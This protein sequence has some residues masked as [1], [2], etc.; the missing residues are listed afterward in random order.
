MRLRKRLSMAF[1]A[2]G[3]AIPTSLSAAIPPHCSDAPLTPLQLTN[4]MI[5]IDR[6]GRL[7]D[8]ASKQ[9]VIDENTYVDKLL[10]NIE[11]AKK[12]GEITGITLYIHGGLNRWRDAM[13]RASTRSGCMLADQKYPVFIGWD[14]RPVSNYADH[15]F[16]L[17]RGKSESLLWG[18]ASSP[19]VLLEDITRSVVRIL[20][21]YYKEVTNPG[22]VERQISRPEQLQDMLAGDQALLSPAL[23]AQ[24]RLLTTGE[25]V[26]SSYIS[27]LSALNPGKLIGAPLV[28]GLGS[29]TWSSL[30]RRTAFVLDRREVYE[31]SNLSSSEAD[32][33][34][35]AATHFLDALR[36]RSSTT[37]QGV[38]LT[39]IGHSM[40]TIVATHILA[41]HPSL[42][43][44]N[45]VFMGAAAPLRSLE[46][47]VSPWLARDQEAKFYNLSLDPDLEVSEKRLWDLAPRGSLLHWIDETLASVN[48]FKDRTAGDWH[49]I[50]HTA[51]EIFSVSR[52]DSAAAPSVLSQ[53][54]LTRFGVGKERGPQTHGDFDEYCFWH[55]D[56]WL[57]R[58]APVARW[59]ACATGVAAK[60]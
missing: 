45:V 40:G 39:L 44:D 35:T 56:F 30:L 28:D 37:L 27:Y 4:H 7:L 41:R 11:A 26:S 51:R 19:F 2:M 18:I 22:L 10:A 31:R 23:S 16:R 34:K 38:E 1:V 9:Q 20:P 25:G 32:R 58:N 59:P 42:K 46:D 21:S 14:A 13:S 24:A 43:I 55:T 48:S 29:G 57:P 50:S 36:A 53:V 60:H 33:A 47:V 17:R 52:P 5:Y 15:L 3:L 12:A 49:N 6:S 54:Y 8:P